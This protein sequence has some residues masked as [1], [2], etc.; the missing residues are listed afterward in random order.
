MAP[1]MLKE[2]FR[3]RDLLGIILAVVGAAVVVLS[4]NEQ[5]TAVSN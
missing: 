4:S 1:L 2:V 5:E 3:K